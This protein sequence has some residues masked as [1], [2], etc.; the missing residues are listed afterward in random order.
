MQLHMQYYYSITQSQRDCD[1]HAFKR[2]Y[3]V[4]IYIIKQL[5]ANP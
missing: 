1:S 3:E 5:S 2:V 4:Y